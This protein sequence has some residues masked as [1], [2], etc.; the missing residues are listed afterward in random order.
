MQHD[1]GV[2]VLHG[3]DFDLDRGSSGTENSYFV[4][5][6]PVTVRGRWEEAG[7]RAVGL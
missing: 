7:R 5:R 2:L 3:E 1:A 4:H 6:E